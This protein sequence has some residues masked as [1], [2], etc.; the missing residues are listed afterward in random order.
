MPQ[1]DRRA[2]VVVAKNKLIVEL[3][4]IFGRIEGPR[5]ILM[6]GEMR[7]RLV[8]KKSGCS[9]QFMET[10]NTQRPIK[11]LKEQ[12]NARVSG[13]VLFFYFMQEALIPCELAI[14]Q[15]KRSRVAIVDAL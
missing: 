4:H 15:I 11:L 14:G 13:V 5:L 7:H 2:R 1:G 6:H 8:G 10:R 9:L 12:Q 3:Q